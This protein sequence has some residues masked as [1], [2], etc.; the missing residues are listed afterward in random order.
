MNAGHL[1]S[2]ACLALRSGPGPRTLRDSHF[3]SRGLGVWLASM[4]SNH[5]VNAGFYAAP[6]SDAVSRATLLAQDD[7]IRSSRIPLRAGSEFQTQ[8]A[9][10]ATADC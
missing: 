7:A 2:L 10:P 9:R 6:T 1:R 5:G 8:S 3:T 4:R